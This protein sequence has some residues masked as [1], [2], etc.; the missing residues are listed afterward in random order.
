[1][2]IVLNLK[3]LS[4]KSS[5]ENFILFQIIFTAETSTFFP[6]NPA[7]RTQKDCLTDLL[8]LNSDSINF[9]P[10]LPLPV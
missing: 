8:L 2:K 9:E 7:K 1:V 6:G 5:E 4:K 10:R 3:E